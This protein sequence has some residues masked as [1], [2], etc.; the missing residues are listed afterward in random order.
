M[1]VDGGR[2]IA[3]VS[4]CTLTSLSDGKGPQK[5]VAVGM[6]FDDTSSF[7]AMCHVVRTFPLPPGGFHHV[8]SLLFVSLGFDSAGVDENSLRKDG[9]ET[10]CLCLN[11]LRLP[12]IAQYG[13]TPTVADK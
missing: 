4:N 9:G 5:F 3:P 10:R 6:E 13:P 7:H 12:F 2:T 1:Q 11:D 8:A